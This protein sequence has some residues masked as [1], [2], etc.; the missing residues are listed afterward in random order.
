MEGN[1]RYHPA[2]AHLSNRNQTHH[3]AYHKPSRTICQGPVV[4]DLRQRSGW[5][6]CN[7]CTF[8]QYT[9]WT[10]GDNEHNF[11][12]DIHAR[13]WRSTSTDAVCYLLKSV[14][15]ANNL[16]TEKLGKHG[17]SLRLLR[18]SEDL[19]TTFYNT[20]DRPTFRMPDDAENC[21]MDHMQ[22]SICTCSSAEAAA[23]L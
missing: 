3:T 21:D 13:H 9:T 14:C 8:F 19:S 10:N 16:H 2:V 1:V 23:C 20:R 15:T 18:S 12:N 22:P 11:P 7:V 5:G 4:S 6:Q 17:S